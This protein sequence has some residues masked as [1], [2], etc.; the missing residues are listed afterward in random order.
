MPIAARQ[1]HRKTDMTTAATCPNCA[2]AATAEPSAALVSFQR[3]QPSD[4][5]TQNAHLAG[6]SLT[7]AC[8]F[9]G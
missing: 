1:S 9:G 2:A 7:S 6:R 3:M 8:H 5:L 4:P